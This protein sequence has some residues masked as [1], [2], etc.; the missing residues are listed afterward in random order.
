MIEHS[1]RQTNRDY[2][3]IYIYR[4][5]VLNMMCKQYK[6]INNKTGLKGSQEPFLLTFLPSNIKDFSQ[7]SHLEA[8]LRAFYLDSL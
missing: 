1:N 6:D 5:A 2:N 8:S 4:Y 3:F 7:Y